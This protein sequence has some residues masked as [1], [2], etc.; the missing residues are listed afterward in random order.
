M[1]A[2]RDDRIS[3]RLNQRRRERMV[4]A[5]GWVV[6]YPEPARDACGRVT[7]R[8]MPD[9]GH[10]RELR[11]ACGRITQAMVCRPERPVE[12]AASVWPL[13]MDSMPARRISP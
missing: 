1:P 9:L 8:R 10:A 11:T 6:D 5:V 7:K 2:V 12:R 13:G 4:R 3:V